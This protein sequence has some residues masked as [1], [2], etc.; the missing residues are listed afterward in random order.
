MAETYDYTPSHSTT[1]LPLQPYTPHPQDHGDL[2]S[3][4]LYPYTDTPPARNPH[5]YPEP[6]PAHV[7]RTPSDASEMYHAISTPEPAPGPGGYLD[8]PSVAF[9]VPRPSGGEHR[10]QLV[11]SGYARVG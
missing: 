5:L 3:L 9:P 11:D 8:P 10:V 6:V 7:A 1:Q 4:P 2:G